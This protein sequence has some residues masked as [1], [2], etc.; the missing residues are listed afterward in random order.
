MTTAHLPHAIQHRDTLLAL[1]VMEA[2]LG[3]LLKIAKP[4]SKLATRCQTVSRWIDECSPALKVKRLSSG[5]PAPV[6]EP[7]AE[8]E[9]VE[10]EVVEDETVEVVEDVEAE[11][12]DTDDT[13]DEDM[14]KAL[15]A[16]AFTIKVG[17]VSDSARYMIPVQNRV[18]PFLSTLASKSLSG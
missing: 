2:A 11:A 18:L 13:T 6:V 17:Q 10:T 5:A 15:P 3:I 12:T 7:P 14:F 4:G 1:T 9:V 8:D 16:E